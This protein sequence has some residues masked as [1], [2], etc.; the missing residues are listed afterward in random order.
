MKIMK[1]ISKFILT[2]FIC[3]FSISSKAQVFVNRIDI[4]KLPRLEYCEIVGIDM[5]IFK[6]KLQVVIDFGQPIHWGNDMSISE[7][8]LGEAKIFNT[9]IHALNFMSNNGWEYVDAYAISEPSG[10]KVYHYL[11]RK[12]KEF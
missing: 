4:N 2:I 9:M 6:K 1:S 10:G 7:D 5:G 8:T 12:K 3:H 11:L